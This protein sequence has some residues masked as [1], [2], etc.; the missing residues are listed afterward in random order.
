MRKLILTGTLIVAA[1]M[2]LP[3]IQ[4]GKPVKDTTGKS[5]VIT[6]D[7]V[8]GPSTGSWSSGC[9]WSVDGHE[10][11]TGSTV[12]G[13]MTISPVPTDLNVVGASDGTLTWDTHGEVIVALDSNSDWVKIP[14]LSQGTYY[15]PDSNDNTIV[16]IN[17]RFYMPYVPTEG[18]WI[19]LTG[20]D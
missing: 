8:S 12:G 1:L 6:G 16:K 5:S 13:K 15:C 9:I 20:S 11:P 2:L 10:G 18:K 17:L 3:V 7:I 14:R 4:G 19:E